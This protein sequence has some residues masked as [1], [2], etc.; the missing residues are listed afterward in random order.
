MW[1]YHW[2]LFCHEIFPCLP[3]F[4]YEFSLRFRKD[5]GIVQSIHKL[6]TQIHYLLIFYLLSVPFSIPLL[7]CPKTARNC[8]ESSS[9]PSLGYK[10]WSVS[11]SIWKN[12]PVSLSIGRKF[13]VLFNLVSQYFPSETVPLFPAG[14]SLKLT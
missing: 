11:V 9:W 2:H 3:P 6:S 4:Y 7:H 13:K 8:L 10:R 5:L 1:A 12:T 14:I